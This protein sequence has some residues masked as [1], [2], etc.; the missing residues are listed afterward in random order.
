MPRRDALENIGHGCVSM[1]YGMLASETM[2]GGN[3]AACIT[4]DGYIREGADTANFT[5]KGIVPSSVG[6]QTEGLVSGV[7][8]IQVLSGIACWMDNDATNP[9]TIADIGKVC[10]MHDATHVSVI[11]GVAQNLIAGVVM[12]VDATKGVKIWIKPLGE[13]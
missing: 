1:S 2:Y 11:A 9:V 10:Y 4:T 12:D 6:S 13:L 8:K 5:C 7:T 3:F